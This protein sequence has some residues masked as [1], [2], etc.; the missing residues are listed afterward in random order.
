[1]RAENRHWNLITIGDGEQFA[2]I[3][4]GKIFTNKAFYLVFVIINS[5]ELLF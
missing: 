5:I 4:Y 3:I 1:M 2:F